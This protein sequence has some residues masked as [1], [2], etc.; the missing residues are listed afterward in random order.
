MILEFIASKVGQKIVNGARVVHFV[1][2]NKIGKIL[3]SYWLSYKFYLQ[4][5][6]RLKKNKEYGY[7]KYTVVSACYN[8]SLYIDE[9][10]DSITKQSLD[11]KKNIH[12][13][14]VDDGS[15]DDTATIILKWQSQYPK[16]ITYI[17]QE[18][19]GQASARNTGL[20]ITKT[21]FIT[22][23]DPDDFVNHDYFQV[24]DNFIEYTNSQRLCMICT[25][26]IFYREKVKSFA[27]NHP[28]S[29]K[30]KKNHMMPVSKMDKNIQLGT[31]STFFKTQLILKNGL[32]FDDRIKPNFEDAHFLLRYLLP[33]QTQSVAFLKD[34]LYY[35]RKR[36]NNSSSLDTAWT[37]PRLFN[38]VLQYGC[39]DLA[40]LYV[41][42]HSP[43]PDY[44]QNTLLYH[45][46]WYIKYLVNNP[47]KIAFL[48]Q[49][50]QATYYYLMKSCF[51]YIENT[52]IDKFNLAGCWFYH[53]VGI[54]NCFKD[55]DPEFQIAYIERYDHYKDEILIRYFCG[56]VKEEDV[57]V[58]NQYV[59]PTHAKTSRD[60][61]C[62][63]TFILQRWLWIPLNANVN[64]CLLIEIN[65]VPTRISL[66]KKQYHD[67]V[68]LRQIYSTF[69]EDKRACNEF[70][71]TWLL[72]DRNSQADDNAE[73]LYRYILRNHSEV[74][75]YF[76]LEKE[77]HDWQRLEEEGFKLLP[78]G[79]KQHE[80][81]LCSC[82][83]I[84]S[85]NIDHYITN[86][87]IDHSL[88]KKQ[89]IF[90]QHG[91]THN[92]ISKWINSKHRIDLFT[93]VTL[94][95][96][97]SICGVGSSYRYSTK[98]VQ[99]TGFARHDAL[100][101]NH[102]AKGSTQKQILIMP[103]WRN[104]LVGQIISG[105]DRELNPEFMQSD[106]AQAWQS[107]LCSEKFADLV[108]K[109]R[110][111]VVF[112]PHANIQPYLD[113]FNLPGWIKIIRHH[114]GSVQAIFNSASM[115]ITDFSSVAFEMAYLKKPVSYYQF[116]EADFYAKQWQYGYFDYRRDG[117]GP[118]CIDE[119]SLLDS[120]ETMLKNE[121]EPEDMY[122][123][124]MENT[125]PFR[126]GKCCERIFN[127]ICDLDNPY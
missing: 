84:I 57:Y 1:T 9:Y 113:D 118:V 124:R 43:I 74:N 31:N 27:D 15:T 96:S 36:E 90:L 29:F 62:G 73:H 11:F 83:K 35:Y 46:I 99:L 13:I 22:F 17:Y 109:H 111:S 119:A 19:A 75:A 126:D 12:I 47:E 105:N 52:T 20:Q 7:S 112:F 97:L 100:L 39:L 41:A 104:Y 115:M 86:Y 107:F 21:P 95:E 56:E 102:N 98:E 127:K 120:V 44:V 66:D 6:K 69:P 16:N 80:K 91:V 18:N 61:F 5:K 4:K 88:E 72:M 50:E 114:E 108:Q 92:N 34:A 30:F 8:V 38:D 68:S 76:V 70:T 71:H 121:G 40:R 63:R 65:N 85:S 23:I 14:C 58:D 51:S 77:S 78:Y 64:A 67:G 24:V 125:F 10:F 54:L 28:L 106:Y 122:L 60:D 94:N 49:E 25:H 42:K 87:F 101:Q 103:T 110:Y 45:I 116:D 89:F 79:S 53:K 82:S 37:D 81:A 123:E 55:I 32:L 2:K 33:C 59:T 3:F 26:L 93:V 117:F 48:T